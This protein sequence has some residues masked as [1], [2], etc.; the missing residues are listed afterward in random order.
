MFRLA[1]NE[2]YSEEIHL[3]KTNIKLSNSSSL[4][5]VTP[6]LDENQILH[7][8]GRME[9]AIV[10]KE[11]KSPIILLKGSR[12]IQLLVMNF[13]TNYKHFNHETVIFQSSVKISA[14]CAK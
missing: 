3:S 5:K 10:P 13:H 11:T 2:I 6:K 14:K 9:N 7:V 12:I 1:Q 4:Y 8:E